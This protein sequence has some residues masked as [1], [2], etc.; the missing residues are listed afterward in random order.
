MA[1]LG[2]YRLP[3]IAAFRVGVEAATSR[4]QEAPMSAYKDMGNIEGKTEIG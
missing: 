1:R 4:S 3:D 2:K